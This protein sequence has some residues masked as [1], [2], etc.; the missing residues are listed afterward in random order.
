MAALAIAAV[1]GRY[2]RRRADDEQGVVLIW[3]A[4]TLIGLVG[5]GALAVDVGNWY[6]HA[7]R[8]QK[9]A[10]AA[11]LSGVVYLP[12]NIPT[13]KNTAVAV[14]TTNGYTTGSTG[15]VAVS[16][17][18][19]TGKPTQLQVTVAKDIPSILAG[20]FGF[21]NLRITRTAVAEYEVPIDMGSPANVYG[22]EPLAAN[23]VG[24]SWSN[25][26]TFAPNMW[27]NIMGFQS[28]KGSGD[29]IQGGQCSS[30]VDRCG[31][32]GA[33]NS[34]Y[35]T[36]GY[37]YKIHVDASQKPTGGN[38]VAIEVFDP[39][40][41]AVGDHC[42]K[43]GFN[44][45]T[46]QTALRASS[47]PWTT[48]NGTAT[49]DADERYMWGDV[50]NNAAASNNGEFCTGDNP[51]AGSVAPVT[52]YRVLQDVN[53]NDPASSPPVAASGNC[54][55][56][57]LTGARPNWSTQSD[58]LNEGSPGYNANIA[59]V[60]RQW[61]PVCVFD[62]ST[63]PAGDYLLQIRTTYGSS[64]D[65]GSNRFSIRAGWVSSGYSFTPGSYS[66]PPT[67]VSG[68]ANGI[69][70]SG[71]GYM[72]LYANAAQNTSPNF[73]MARVL[74]GGSGQTLEIQLFDIGD[75][76]NCSNVT[77][78]FRQ[79]NGTPWSSCT[80][81]PG[82]SGSTSTA[83]PCSITFSGTNKWT[84]VNIP[85]PPDYSCNVSDPTDCWTTMTYK[86]NGSGSYLQDTTTWTAQIKGA[87]V[88]LVR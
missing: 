79:P 10:D 77:L 36:N 83:S 13:A 59:S 56:L 69:T 19:V 43:N 2:L 85:L 74:T 76:T 72:G 7:N 70:I 14:A 38:Y 62:P 86:P 53:P 18:P 11:A 40:A 68:G 41:I 6:V 8:Q 60:F 63:V 73:Y 42:E 67:L 12:S 61:V 29:A 47:N 65:G 32:S 4:L 54:N 21:T 34:D 31:S 9:A 23:D 57:S 48:K 5:I 3:F 78:T 50:S 84:T 75:C 58:L 30:V 16:S 55:N 44:N 26:S 25:V 87:P 28:G 71:T 39:A 49:T 82:D 37:F 15:N 17:A 81:R 80:Y 35:S 22:N 45:G 27:G 51:D 46:A 1:L 20:V 64:T 33:T 24:G 88:R 66:S 52:T